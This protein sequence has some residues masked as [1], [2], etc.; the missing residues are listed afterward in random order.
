MKFK[1][2]NFDAKDKS[3][4]GDYQLEIGNLFNKC[5]NTLVESLG[6]KEGF[7][8]LFIR[9]KTLLW[10][11]VS[12]LL[13]TPSDDQRGYYWGVVIPT[14]QEHF[15]KEKGQFI[16]DQDLHE[17]IKH[18]L[19]R[20]EALYMDRVNQVTGEV[21]KTQ[22]TVSNNGS[23]KETAKYIDAVIVWAAT[24]YGIYIPECAKKET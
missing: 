8:V 23:K 4:W 15:H 1:L 12:A 17:A 24:E 14:I 3:N 16:K 5:R 13:Q 2:F 22:I 7:C 21:Y 19:A 20:D 10:E 6:L 9:K 11:R 18:I